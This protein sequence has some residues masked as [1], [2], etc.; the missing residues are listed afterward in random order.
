MA[1]I[2]KRY[3]NTE[4]A[5]MQ[6]LES[7]FEKK[8]DDVKQNVSFCYFRAINKKNNKLKSKDSKLGTYNVM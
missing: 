6:I 3:L 8:T 2:M 7:S 1:G 4:L 5:T